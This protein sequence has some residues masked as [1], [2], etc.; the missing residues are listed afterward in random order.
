MVGPPSDNSNYEE[1]LVAEED[2]LTADTRSVDSVSGCAVRL[3]WTFGGMAVL[4]AAAIAIARTSV[5]TVGVADVVFWGVVAAMITL[6][7]LDATKFLGNTLYGERATN[8][9]VR[10]YAIGLWIGAAVLWVVGH[11]VHL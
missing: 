3:G 10:R 7:Y 4:F 5:W 8:R 1:I 11:S 2:K 9:H 6:R